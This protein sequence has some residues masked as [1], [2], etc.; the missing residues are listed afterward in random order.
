MQHRFANAHTP[1]NPKP[2]KLYSKPLTLKPS[3]PL[4]QTAQKPE[5]PQSPQLLYLY[6]DFHR[7]KQ[8]FGSLVDPCKQTPL[9]SPKSQTRTYQI[10]AD[11]IPLRCSRRLDFLGLY[12]VV[13]R[14]SLVL[15]WFRVWV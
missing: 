12:D 15:E 6:L 11:R 14:R 8:P 9:N 10:L 3:S 13:I 7:I 5:T 1:Q 4:T 2:H